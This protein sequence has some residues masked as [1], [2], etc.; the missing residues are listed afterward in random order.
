MERECSRAIAPEPRQDAARSRPRQ[1]GGAP[2]NGDRAAGALLQELRNWEVP[3]GARGLEPL[4]AFAPVLGPFH[5]LLDF[6]R[7][8]RL[9][10]FGAALF[11]AFADGHLTGARL[12]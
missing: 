8:L 12:P 9:A 6:A 2:G 3:S 11:C 7:C 1:I 4:I 5:A 10:P